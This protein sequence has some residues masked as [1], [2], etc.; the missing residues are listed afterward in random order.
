MTPATLTEA[1]ALERRVRMILEEIRP[2]LREDTGDVELVGI[3]DG[4]VRVRLL[5]A[6]QGCPS[7]VTTLR[8]GIEQ[9]LLT[10]IPQLRS[11]EAVNP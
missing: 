11:V 10:A 7:S 1:P 6:C 3:D 4:V 9:R 5:G 8:D 2:F